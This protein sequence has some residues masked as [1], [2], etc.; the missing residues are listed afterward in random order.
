VWDWRYLVT[1]PDLPQ[2]RKVLD[3]INVRFYL[4]Y[5]GDAAGAAKALKHVQSSDME[6]YESPTA[7]P[8]AFF[9]DSV[10]VYNDLPQFCSWLHAGDG[11]PFAAIEHSDWVALQP[12]PRVSADLATRKV[13]PADGYVLTSN[14]TSFTVNAAG[15]GFIVLT[16][17]Y[18][19]NNFHA[20]LNGSRVP[21][22]RINHAFKGI[23]VDSPG[24]YRVEYEYYPRG[25]EGA[26][27]LSAA[28]LVL[29]TLAGAY[30]IRTRPARTPD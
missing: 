18:E 7:W 22:I 29:I 17:A 8:R 26:L 3:A 10:A 11:R 23:Y 30:A 13:T 5:R 1:V 14:T 4:L 20:T 15:P 27:W 6:V 12:A 19:R 28:G 9:T 16:E 21:Y 25:L 2:V 24:T